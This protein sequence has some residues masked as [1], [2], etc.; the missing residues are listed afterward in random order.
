[1]LNRNAFHQ[2]T[3]GLHPTAP[4]SRP[5]RTFVCSAVAVMSPWNTPLAMLGFES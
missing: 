1:M 3:N 2:S 4:R 5:S